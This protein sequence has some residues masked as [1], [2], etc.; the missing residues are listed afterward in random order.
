M[1]KQEHDIVV[2]LNNSIFTINK[3]NLDRYCCMDMVSNVAEITNV[4]MGDSL[5][6]VMIAIIVDRPNVRLPPLD[7]GIGEE[8]N[9]DDIEPNVEN[10]DRDANTHEVDC[11]NGDGHAG[12]GG[13]NDDMD[14]N[15][16]DVDDVNDDN[17]YSFSSKDDEWIVDGDDAPDVSYEHNDDTMCAL[18][19][20][21]PF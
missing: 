21:T 5:S 17:V 8:S 6:K 2:N 7:V 15:K 20:M 13:K 9:V 16:H 14:A 4:F 19:V 3:V 10:D 18:G 12:G 1:G 11:V